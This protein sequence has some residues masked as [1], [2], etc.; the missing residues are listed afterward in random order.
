LQKPLIMITLIQ[1]EYIVA[2]EKFKNFVKASEAC[3]VTQPTLSM[4]IKKLEEDLGVVIFDRT[5]KPV[6]PTEVGRKI[7]E[8]GKLVLHHSRRISEIIEVFHQRISGKMR[9]GIIP[10]LAPYLLPRF[11]GNFK[12]KYP[13]VQFSIREMIT[14]KIAEDLLNDKLDAGIF[15]T[16]Y[17]DSRFKEWPIF[18]EE[19]KIYASADHRLINKTEILIKDVETPEIWLLSDGHCFR[20]QVINLCSIPENAESDLPF[21]F[22]GGSLD[23]LM[24]IIDKEGGFT[25]LPEIAVMDLP[26]SKQHQIRSFDNYKPLREVSLIFSRNFAKDRLIK[27]LFKEVQSCVPEFMHNKDRGSIVEWREG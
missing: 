10:T 8:Q 9:I 26:D 18:Y 7:I 27:L 12:K 11:A 24:K 15:V 4:Q 1:L 19:M 13:E 22:E 23:T 3:F 6:I 14:E 2:V 20:D 5:K 17:H 16:P 21:E 25:L